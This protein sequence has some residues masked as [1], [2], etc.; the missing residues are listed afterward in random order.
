MPKLTAREETLIAYANANYE[1]G[2]DFMVECYDAQDW[3]DLTTTFRLPL[4]CKKEMQDRA[5]LNQE[6]EEECAF[7]YSKPRVFNFVD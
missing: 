6:Q 7:E 4:P 5:K 3:I 2:M 1:Q